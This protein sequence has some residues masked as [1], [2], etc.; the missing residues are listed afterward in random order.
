MSRNTAAPSAPARWAVTRRPLRS[1]SA[2]RWCA[3]APVTWTCSTLPRTCSAAAAPAGASRLA[4][5]A[6]TTAVARR[7]RKPSHGGPRR[8]RQA[9]V[10]ALLGGLVPR[11]LRLGRRCK[12]RVRT[13]GWLPLGRL[14]VRRSIRRRA[15]LLTAA[16]AGGRHRGRRLRRGCGRDRLRGPR[17]AGAVGVGRCVGG[18]WG[19]AAAAEGA[20]RD[21][22]GHQAEDA[23]DDQHERPLRD[24]GLAT[25]LAW[26][27]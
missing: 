4:S 18:G 14:G 11:L 21:H 16:V 10:G 25:P 23:G 17:R 2:R 19:L 27:G 12:R 24:G 5:A 6:R 8:T 20:L 15:R 26:D 13:V 3:L 1:V 7:M 9:A 22:G